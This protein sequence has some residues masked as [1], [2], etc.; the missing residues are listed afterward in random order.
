M[1]YLAFRPG[2]K[3]ARHRHQRHARFQA[4]SSPTRLTCR[5]SATCA[6]PSCRRCCTPTAGPATPVRCCWCCRAWTPRARA[7]SSNTL[8]ERGNPQGIRYTSFGKPT[9]EE[10]AHHYLWRIRNALPAG[11]PHRGVRPL[12]LRGRADRPGAQPGAARRLGR[13]LR[14]DQRVR[15]ANSS[16][17][18]RRS[19]RWRCSSRSTSRRSDWPSGS[20]GPTNTGSTTP[21][22]STNACCGRCT[23]RPTRRAGPDVNGLRAVARHAVRP[24][25]VQP[26]GHHRAAHRGAEAPQHVLAA[27]G[28]RR[29][30]PRRSGWRR[31]SLCHPA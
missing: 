3:V 2:D 22:T 10:L 24:E 29:R 18:A 9:E 16:T 23:R 28:F 27:T 13:A 14:R 30:R 31:A 8:S 6:S 12:A 4:A 21:P 1:I 26:A 7:E 25:V 19:S 5:R 20:N 15:E 11:G 17:A